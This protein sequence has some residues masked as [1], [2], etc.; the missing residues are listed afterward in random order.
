MSQRGSNFPKHDTDARASPLGPHSASAGELKERLE[1]ERAG[2]AFL[3]YRDHDGPQQIRVLDGKGSFTIGRHEGADIVL[4]GDP[5]VSSIHA[6]LD[7]AGEE[8][9]IVD[10][11]LSR[12]G[13]YVNGERL[14][15]RR[16]L[17][18]GDSIRLGQT[19]V[20]FKSSQDVFTDTTRISPD[21]P[22]SEELS[23]AQRRVLVALC[24]PLKG[25]AGYG[26]AASNKQIA[27]ELFLSVEGVKTH[28]RTLFSKFGVEQ[29][30]QNQKRA[31]LAQLAF[32]S[33]V[34]SE[35]DL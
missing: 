12:N 21:R 26:A 29:L 2:V 3:V 28:I 34:V 32:E 16:L 8:W 22:L 20:A 23:P 6:Q 10:D 18:D 35:R 5:E 27:E 33:G 17:K 13:T 25:S 24:R 30:P 31:R 7:A 4:S 15:A 14:Q 19:L 11:G 1:A 9:V